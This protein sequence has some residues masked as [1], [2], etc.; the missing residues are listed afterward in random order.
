MH[1]VGSRIWPHPVIRIGSP[2]LCFTIAV[3]PVTL[4]V[5]LCSGYG[6]GP[7]IHQELIVVNFDVCVDKNSLVFPFFP[8]KSLFL[9]GD[10]LEVH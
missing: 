7:H 6:T 2:R 1:Y 10:M 8:L 5:E 9:A 4:G 3:P